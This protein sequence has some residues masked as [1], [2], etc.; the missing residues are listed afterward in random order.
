M[1]HHEI[2]KERLVARHP[3]FDV[4]IIKIGPRIDKGVYSYYKVSYWCGANHSK[5]SQ[6]G[7]S[8]ETEEQFNNDD[9]DAAMRSASL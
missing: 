7:G 8:N 5:G 3:C 1:N 2:I 9:L 4:T 6:I